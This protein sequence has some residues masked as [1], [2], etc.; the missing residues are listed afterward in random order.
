MSRAQ[1]ESETRLIDRLVLGL[2]TP[3]E[4][5]RRIARL[6]EAGWTLAEIA[7]E[8]DTSDNALSARLRRSREAARRSK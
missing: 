2:P 4:M 5:L 7:A 8:F 3:A 6:R 1:K